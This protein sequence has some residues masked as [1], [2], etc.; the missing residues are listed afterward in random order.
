VALDASN[1]R[2]GEEFPATLLTTGDTPQDGLRQLPAPR[3]GDRD[4]AAESAASSI[5]DSDI[6]PSPRTLSRHETVS[7]SK[8][9]R[10]DSAA[11]TGP[12]IAD[13]ESEGEEIGFDEDFD[14]VED[15]SLGDVP[16]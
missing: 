11:A 15:I 10:T 7:S 12:E 16:G 5:P 2:E 6:R 1:P 13:S 8:R 14:W 4:P 3:A 9:K